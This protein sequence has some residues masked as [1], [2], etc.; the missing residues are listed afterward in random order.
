MKKYSKTE[1]TVLR[2]LLYVYM[3]KHLRMYIYFLFLIENAE[4]GV[5]IF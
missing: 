4:N 1:Q 3:Y 2:V 5:R